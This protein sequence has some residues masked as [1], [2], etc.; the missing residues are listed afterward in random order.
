MWN[1]FLVQEWTI[2][3][4]DWKNVVALWDFL[5]SFEEEISNYVNYVK[6]WVSHLINNEANP[7]YF[8][9][10]TTEYWIATINIADLMSKH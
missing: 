1:E 4:L 5:V 9:E 7:W 10:C 6:S 2:V 3:S 8:V